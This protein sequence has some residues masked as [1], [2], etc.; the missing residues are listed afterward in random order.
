MLV[1]K[2]TNRHI[3]LKKIKGLNHSKPTN[4]PTKD[5]FAI[6][7]GQDWFEHLLNQP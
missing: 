7:H 5:R 2:N 4:Q 1:E 3:F 6:L